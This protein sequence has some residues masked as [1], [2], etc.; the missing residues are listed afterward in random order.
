[1]NVFG[2]LPTDTIVGDHFKIGKLRRQAMDVCVTVCG[3]GNAVHVL[4]GMLADRVRR[5]NLYVSTGERASRWKSSPGVEVK[6]RDGAV[7]Y[8][9]RPTIVSCSAAEVI[10]DADLVLLSVPAYS[11]KKY[12]T[13]I[14][15]NLRSGGTLVAMPGSGGFHWI[16][17]SVARQLQLRLPATVGGTCHLPM[18]CR[19]DRYSR[20][21]CLLSL[22]DEIKVAATPGTEVGR[23]ADLLQALLKPI[24]ITSVRH[25]ILCNLYPA[26]QIIHTSR[27]F[28]LFRGWKPGVSYA[29]NQDFY[30]SM[31]SDTIRI[32]QPL[33]DELGSICAALERLAPRTHLRQDWDDIQT[34]MIKY[35]HSSIR[36]PETLLGCFTTNRA[37]AGLTTPMIQGRDHRWQPDWSHRYMTEDIPFGLCV[38]KGIAETAQVPTPMTDAIISWAQR[39]LGKLYLVDHALVGSDVE[40]TAAPQRFG[41]FDVETLL[42]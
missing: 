19:W 23:V 36:E 11:L 16:V 28:E 14:L 29:E 25:L 40:E 8:S 38:V 24:R 33:S 6:S 41:K 42:A 4:V 26:N 37:Y 7:L 32:L 2:N 34:A 12:L 9:G 21:A 15:P 20:S 22:K 30:H 39:H 35:Y 10:P 27:L 5:L 1:M 3:G 31:G 13:A 18:T 17:E